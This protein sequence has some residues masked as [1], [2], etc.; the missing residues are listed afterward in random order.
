MDMAAQPQ[1]PSLNGIK[2]R[3]RQ[4]WSSGNY[5]KEG[6]RFVLISELLCEAVDLRS[7]HRVLDVATGNGNTAL[8]AARR[9]STVVGIDYVPALLE[10]GRKRAGAEGLE[11]EFREADAENLPFGDG[12]FDVVL[13]TLGVMF[14]PDQDKAA[15]ELL[16]VCKSGGKIGLASWTPDSFVGALFQALGKYLPPPPGLRPPLLWG[17]EERLR[18]FFGE[19]IDSLQV[20]RR[21]F[22][23][24]FPSPQFYLEHSRAYSG[25][26]AK[27]LEMLDSS[28]QEA[29]LRDIDEV[30]HRFNRSGDETML[31]PSDYLQVVIHRK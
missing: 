28:G 1:A 13:S 4:A 6:V 18:E 5:A 17:T 21:S 23:F 9:F 15:S 30:V 12:S 29:L 11:V 14:A 2:E 20:E 26:L 10:D 16:R 25:P 31:A 27:A 7:N 24:H 22:V 3:Q 8:A 19:G